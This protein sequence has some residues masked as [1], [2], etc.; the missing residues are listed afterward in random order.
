M[1]LGEFDLQ[2]L[3]LA[4]FVSDDVLD[5]PDLISLGPFLVPDLIL[6]HFLDV[7][8]LL[9]LLFELLGFLLG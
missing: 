9:G 2:V 5:L 7:V 3:V 6:D 4:Y 8:V 1:V